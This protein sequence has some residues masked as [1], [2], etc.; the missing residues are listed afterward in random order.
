MVPRFSKGMLRGQISN[1]QGEQRLSNLPPTLPPPST[2]QAFVASEYVNPPVWRTI[3]RQHQG[4]EVLAMGTEPLS[5]GNVQMCV[6]RKRREQT[7]RL[8]RRLVA[9]VWWV[10]FGGRGGGGNLTPLDPNAAPTLTP[11]LYP[12]P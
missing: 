10:G 3:F 4:L 5:L 2:E 7:P 1:D 8:S 6:T 11:T 12:H 9:F